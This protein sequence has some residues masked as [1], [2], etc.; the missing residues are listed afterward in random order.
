MTTSKIKLQSIAKAINTLDKTSSENVSEKDDLKLTIARQLLFDVITSNS[1]KLK[2][3]T[4][5]LIKSD[6]IL[7]QLICIKKTSKKNKYILY[8]T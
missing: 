4:R 3:S 5:R 6:K 1:Y 7:N 2:Y 8:I